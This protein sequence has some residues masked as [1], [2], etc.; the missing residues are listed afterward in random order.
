MKRIAFA[1]ISLLGIATLAGCLAPAVRNIVIQKPAAIDAGKLRFD[2]ATDKP[3]TSYR[4]GEEMVFSFTVKNNQ[5]LPDG[6]QFFVIWTRSGDDGVFRTGF[7]PISEGQPVKVRTAIATPGFVRMKVRLTDIAGRVF[8]ELDGGAGANVEEILPA[9]SEPADFDAFWAKCHDDLAKLPVKAQLAAVATN[10]MPAGRIATHT[11][12]AVT[13]ACAGPRPVTGFL[14]MPKDAQ[15]RSLPVVVS[16]DGYGPGLQGGYPGE[17]LYADDSIRFHVNA[18]GYDLMREEA[19]YK[20]FFAARSDYAMS[21]AENKKPETAYFHGMAMRVMRAFDFV[22]T[23]PE[24]NGKDLVAQGGSQGGLQTSWAGSLVKGLTV[25]RPSVTW[26]A[27]VDGTSIGRLGGWRPAYAPGLA[28]Y[29]A[30]LHARRIPQSCR[31]VISRAGL[32]DYVCPPS[33]LA[34]QYNAAG[35]PKSIAWVQ[36]STHMV[37]PPDKREYVVSAPAGQAIKGQ[38]VR[39]RQKLYVADWVPAE[40]TGNWILDNGTSVAPIKFSGRENLRIGR[41]AKGADLPVMHVVKLAGELDA[42]RAGEAVIGVG[43][44]WWW[45]CRVNGKEIFGRPHAI[46]G[47]NAK[48][49]FEKTDWIFRVPVLKGRNK[50]E[51]DV[52]LGQHGWVAIGTIGN[53]LIEKGISL[54]PENDYRFFTGNFRRPD[55]VPFEPVRGAGGTVAFKTAQAFPA[56]IEYRAAD[57]KAW[58]AVWDPGKRTSHKVRLALD[59]DKEYVI[60]PVQHVFR[61]DWEVARGAER[62]FTSR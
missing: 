5:P 8:A 21:I 37:V 16:F 13:V 58:K 53:E 40:F 1:C 15:A 11:L 39:A 22:K 34:A 26:C 3:P 47:A 36:N 24:W 25:C 60:R 44:D 54:T 29:D 14:A 6:M 12:Q 4:V 30:A 43:A 48:S 20:D 57:E 41:G 61:G 18:H 55:S 19:Y 23:L 33:G 56:G 9:T 2:S 28:Y 46:P 62:K 52:T 17:S 7:E 35:C 45:T 42:R 10:H 59:P 51:L 31:L 50:V 38:A 32:G 49:S 27:D